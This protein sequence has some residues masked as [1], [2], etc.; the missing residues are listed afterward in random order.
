[1][2]ICSYYILN[3]YLLYIL[4]EY[5]SNPYQRWEIYTSAGF[6]NHSY[7]ICV[8]SALLSFFKLKF[9]YVFERRQSKTG[10]ESNFLT[11]IYEFT[12]IT[13]T[14]D[15]LELQF[16]NAFIHNFAQL[17]KAGRASA[18][19]ATTLS[20]L[21]IPIRVSLLLLIITYCCKAFQMTQQYTEFN[22][23]WWLNW[24]QISSCKV[25]W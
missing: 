15:R 21:Q 19:R 2:H 4:H 20:L 11:L 16:N 23:L 5:Q 7:V 6:K 12:N 25:T 10:C 14:F 3:N 17:Q 18:G 1:M 13:I 9:A 24:L 22:F 8:F